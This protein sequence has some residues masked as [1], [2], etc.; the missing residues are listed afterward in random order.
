MERQAPVIETAHLRLR[1]FAP[2]DLDALAAIY[3]DEAVMRYNGGVRDRAQ[4]EA[5]IA[6][7]RAEWATHGHGDWAVTDV[8]DGALFG[9][10]GYVERGRLGYALAQ[11]AWGRGLAT[12]AAGACLRYGFERLGFGEIVASAARENGASR[13]VLEK[14]GMR[15]HPHP[16]L[17]ADGG[18]YY[19]IARA[20]YRPPEAPFHVRTAGG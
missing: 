7:Y 6:R 20:E 8:A 9:I 1:G 11:A 17:E 13:H 16:I 5:A 4:T 18:V 15:Q 12:E 10:C 2:G 3:A 19:V 14:L